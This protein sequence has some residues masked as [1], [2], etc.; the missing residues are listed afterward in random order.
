[1][2]ISADLQVTA[3]PVLAAPALTFWQCCFCDDL[4]CCRGVD[5]VNVSASHVG[6]ERSRYVRSRATAAVGVALQIITCVC[7]WHADREL[8]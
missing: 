2:N 3:E 6:W 4:C 7:G 1:M 5:D 8:K